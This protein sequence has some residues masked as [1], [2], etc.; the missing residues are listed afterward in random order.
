MAG[1]GSVELLVDRL[2]DYGALVHC[3]PPA[4]GPAAIAE[5][6]RERAALPA[7]L[8][9][10]WPAALPQPLLDSV[11]LDVSG[12]SAVDAVITSVRGAGSSRSSRMCASWWLR[13]SASSPVPDAVAA[14][15]PLSPLTWV[16]G[17]CATGDIE[18][19]KVQAFIARAP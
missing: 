11:Q 16:S 19:D 15:E 12:L 8:P 1:A 3:R 18:L 9:A 17:P 13:T 10:E 7:V 5:V 6:S 4:D 2:A 14:P